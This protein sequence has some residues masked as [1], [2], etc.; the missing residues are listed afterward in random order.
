MG[1]EFV[2]NL[3]EVNW[4]VIESMDVRDVIDFLI[5]YVWFIWKCW[6]IY[7][8]IVVNFVKLVD[9]FFGCM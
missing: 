5:V 2:G 8:M 7:D 4:D 3:V 1:G 9:D 6:I